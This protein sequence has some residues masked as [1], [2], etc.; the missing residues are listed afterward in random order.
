[1]LHSWRW[2]GPKDPVSLDDVQQAGAIGIVTSLHQIP[3]G[4]LWTKEAIQ[5]RQRMIEWD[6]QRNKQRPLFWSVVESLP[7]HEDIKRG[8]ASRDRW[9]ELYQES[10]RNLAA[11]G[12][13]IVCYNFMPILDWTRTN[14]MYEVSDGSKALRYD[15]KEFIAFELFLLKRE[16]AEEAY[17]AD[18]IAQARVWFEQASPERIQDLHDTL[19]AGLP[20]ADET[21]DLETVRDMLATYAEID[22]E[23]LQANFVYFLEQVI[24]VAEE[25]GIRMCVH[26]DDPPFPLL[27]LPRIVST[28][29]HLDYLFGKVPSRANGLTFCTGSFGVRPDND[30]AGMVR[31]WGDRI[32]FAHLRATKREKDGSFFE[33]DHLT[34]DV[35]MYSVVK[36][37]L[38]EEA[39]RT[40][41]NYADVH[42]P[43]RP[44]HGH[45]MLDDLHKSTNPGYS[46]IG[47][48]RGLAEL[49]GLELGIHRSIHASG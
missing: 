4:D 2:Y 22:Q 30:L 44:D 35:D 37:L 17:Q 1:M 33:A 43:M 26:P 19:L 28:D 24:P 49:R 31:K 38:E 29:A 6:E 25:V 15:R 9:I 23:Q 47:R 3:V 41:A 27:G 48:L 20:G 13:E 46:A 45:L 10:L 39:R 11:C 36:A 8:L 40:A 32:H 18:E 12:V 14:L 21:Y 34:G 16:G 42:I 5:T 7:V